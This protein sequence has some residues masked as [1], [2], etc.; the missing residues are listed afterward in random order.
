MTC[1]RLKTRS[2]PKQGND[3]L[4]TYAEH[5][6]A[7]ALVEEQPNHVTTWPL[8]DCSQTGV[9]ADAHGVCASQ[10]IKLLGKGFWDVSGPEVLRSL[11]AESALRRH[12]PSL[13]GRRQ[14]CCVQGKW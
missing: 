1:E 11:Y 2:T 8:D 13:N 9:L 4:C 3:T 5:C 12:C 10:S 6:H 7:S 14:E